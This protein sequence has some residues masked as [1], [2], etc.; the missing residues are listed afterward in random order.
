[1]LRIKRL[2]GFAGV[3]SMR[4]VCGAKKKLF[5]LFVKKQI[6]NQRAQAK[7]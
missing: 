6:F 5:F 2:S 1:L 7:H 3:Y 4:S